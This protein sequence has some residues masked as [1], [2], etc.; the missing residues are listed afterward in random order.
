MIIFATLSLEQTLNKR[1]ILLKMRII[2]AT[3]VKMED[4]INKPTLRS[5][6]IGS[7]YSS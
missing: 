7:M 6:W 2:S 4:L 1:G 3:I 5:L